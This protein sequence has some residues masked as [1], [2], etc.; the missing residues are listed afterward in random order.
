MADQNEKSFQKQDAIFV[1]DKR[2]L[3][4][5][6]GSKK[7]LKRY[8]KNV[9]LGFTT[10]REAK[11]GKFIDKKC[12]FTGNVAIRGRI[13]QGVV[14]STKMNRTIIV[15]RDYMHFIKKYQAYTWW[16][17]LFAKWRHFIG[18][19]STKRKRYSKKKCTSSS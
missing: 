3:T 18:N 1:G 17:P 10:P 15:R 2:Y 13:L 8:Y 4:K 14:K 5:T 12:P 6:A 16:C 9:G 11:E 7:V 19:R